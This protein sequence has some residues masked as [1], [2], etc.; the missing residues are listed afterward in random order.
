MESKNPQNILSFNQ[1]ATRMTHKFNNLPIQVKTLG[2]KKF[3]MTFSSHVMQSDQ[4]ENIAIGNNIKHWYLIVLDK[5]CLTLTID[6]QACTY[7]K[8]YLW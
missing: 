4:V 1:K 7:Q 2:K 5:H 8:Y 3:S 6:Q